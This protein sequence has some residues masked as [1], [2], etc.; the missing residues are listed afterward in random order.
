[1]RRA[2]SPAKWIKWTEPGQILS[3]MQ[4]QRM[5][6]LPVIQNRYSHHQLGARLGSRI[7]IELENTCRMHH[8]RRRT[9]TE[10]FDGAYFSWD[11][12]TS[13]ARKSHVTFRVHGAHANLTCSSRTSTYIDAESHRVGWIVPTDIEKTCA[14]LSMDVLIGFAQDLAIEE[15]SFVGENQSGKGSRASNSQ[16][17]QWTT[18]FFHPFHVF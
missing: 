7:R 12:G 4:A 13:M 10:T 3:M 5:A 16:P 11:V 18:Q 9:H 6:V 15:N 1:M 8:L 14:I 17:H 2:S